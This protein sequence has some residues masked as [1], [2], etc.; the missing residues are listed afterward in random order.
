MTWRAALEKRV[1]E[2]EAAFEK[3]VEQLEE[4]A[5]LAGP[6]PAAPS[7]PVQKRVAS[8]PP[9]TRNARALLQGNY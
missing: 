7:K 1:C 2:L 6:K 5:G 8:A 3:R 9:L 4:A